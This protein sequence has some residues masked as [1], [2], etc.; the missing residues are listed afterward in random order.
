VR[1]LKRES[2]SWGEIRKMGQWWVVSREM[3]KR[4][5]SVGGDALLMGSALDVVIRRRQEW[6]VRACSSVSLP[7]RLAGCATVICG[8]V[9]ALVR[10]V[11]L[12]HHNTSL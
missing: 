10:Q 12:A 6:P 1:A 3:E 4:W 2:G 9:G 8:S 7:L 5:S 11:D